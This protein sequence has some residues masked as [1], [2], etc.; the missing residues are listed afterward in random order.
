M[1]NVLLVEDDIDLADTIID[2]LELTGINCMHV[3][4]GVAGLELA[5]SESY[6][7]L[8]LDI[9]LPR[10]DGFSLCE[11]L[12]RTGDDTPI[13]MLTARDSIADKVE[14]FSAGTDDYLVK[15]F[16]LQELV[17][18]IKALAK[19]RS[20]QA[21]KLSCHDLV[22]DLASKKVEREGVTLKLSPTT[23]KILEVLLRAS[24]KPVSREKIEEAVWG[25]DLPESNNLKVHIFNLRKVVDASFT[26]KLVHTVQGHGFAVKRDVRNED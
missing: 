21:Q 18:R 25:D 2:Y 1:L 19:R 13:L 6:H 11:R 22:M 5:Q 14:G 8:L 9:N 15:P 23:W 17:I 20:G 3:A 4:N 7:V 12:R 10:L 16:L 24:P 26:T